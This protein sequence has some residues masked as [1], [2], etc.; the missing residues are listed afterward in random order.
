VPPRV[1]YPLGRQRHRR[2]A[3]L[4]GEV[5]FGALN[6]GLSKQEVVEVLMHTAPYS[7][8]PKALNALTLAQEVLG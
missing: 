5:V 1:R 4:T 3:R 7:G 8:F 2:D 6:V